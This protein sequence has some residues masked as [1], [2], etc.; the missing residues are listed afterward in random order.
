MKLRDCLFW[1]HLSAGSTA[2][3][4]ILIMSV[5]GTLLA[6]ERQIVDSAEKKVRTVMVPSQDVKRVDL[7]IM[8]NTVR[9]A[10]PQAKIT[11]V[12]IN[13][14]ANSSVYFSFS[15]E[16]GV[17]VNPYSGERLGGA[18]K[19]RDA[20]HTIEDWH[21]WLGSREKGRPVTGACNLAFFVLAVTGFY[22]WWPRQ[23]SLDVL[24]N[25]TLFNPNVTGKARNWNWHNV[26]GFWCAPF[27]IIITLTGAVMSYPWANNLLYRMTGNEPPPVQNRAPGKTENKNEVVKEKSF[28]MDLSVLDKLFIKAQAQAP[29][30]ASINIRFPQKLDAPVVVNIQEKNSGYLNPRSQLTLDAST[31]DVVKWEPFS[32]QNSGRKMRFWARYL[33][34]GEAGGFWGQAIG[35]V[36]CIGGTFLVWTG[37]AMALHRLSAFKKRKFNSQF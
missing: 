34:T 9:A 36:A 30:W 20:M 10:N 37:I 11:A 28:E 21:R 4:I 32:E 5:T 3:L 19:I 17:Y 26:I 16:G 1:M 31:A 14:N 8:T 7:E 2:G 25:I 6:F 27:L 23:W 22:L 13:S 24:K 29:G 15:R 35:F 33:H 12:T 18:S